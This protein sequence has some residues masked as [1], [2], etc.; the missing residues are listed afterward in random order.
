MYGYSC[1]CVFFLPTGTMMF[2]AHI[3]SV[4][5]YSSQAIVLLV[6]LQLWQL[7]QP[8]NNAV[9]ASNIDDAAPRIVDIHAVATI[10]ALP[11]LQILHPLLRIT[12]VATCYGYTVATAVISPKPPLWYFVHC[13]GYY[14]ASTCCGHTAATA[15]VFRPLLWIYCCH[16]CS[17]LSTAVDLG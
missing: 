13:R 2:N 4:F 10:A 11:H 15:M 12:V 17:I 14:A 16:C 3:P 6:S 1:T 8:S 9:C 5:M 7:S